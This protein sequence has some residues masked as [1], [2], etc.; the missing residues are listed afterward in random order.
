MEEM[1]IDPAGFRAPTMASRNS[2]RHSTLLPPR[3]SD[4]VSLIYLFG[5]LF[6]VTA[7]S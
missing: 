6:T 5:S 4:E 2:L 1:Q 7:F 3:P